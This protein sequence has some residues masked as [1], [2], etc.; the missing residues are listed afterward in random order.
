MKK[1]VDFFDSNLRKEYFS[2]T[3]ILTGIYTYITY[4]WEIPEKYKNNLKIAGLFTLAL[5]ILYV[6][7]WFK[8]NNSEK[9]SLNIHGSNLEVKLGDIFDE[10]NLKVIGFNEYFDTIVDDRIISSTSLHGQFINNKINISI[11]DFDKY[12][13]KSLDSRQGLTF[14]E[15]KKRKEGKLRKYPLG[16]I[17][18]YDDYLITALS[19]FDDDNRA[20]LFMKDYINFLI[21]FWNE[22]DIVYAQNSVSIPLLGSGITR[23]KEYIDITDQ[24]LLEIM[25][26]SFKISRIKFNYPSKVSIIIDPRKKDKINFYK[27]K[28]LE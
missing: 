14:N 9:V 19:K 7:L 24:E 28:E 16:T 21:N 13:S 23:F 5:I 22:L 6:Y 15:N 18:K 26:W 27:L 1:K 4:F 3:G 25:I 12:I 11:D 20:Y 10:Q 2:Y 8:A 17:V